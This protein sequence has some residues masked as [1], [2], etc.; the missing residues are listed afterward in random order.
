MNEL[1]PP[2]SA[3]RKRHTA[4]AGTSRTRPI[5]LRL[6]TWCV[7]M[8]WRT[9]VDWR[10]KRPFLTRATA[11]LSIIVLTLVAIA[12]SGVGLP[13]PRAALGE[14]SNGNIAPVFNLAASEP[15]ATPPPV[16]PPSTNWSIGSEADVVARLPIPHTTIPERVRAQVTAYV[17]Q[18]GDT[19]YDI[20]A[21]FGL[22]PDTI[23][24]SNREGI[25]DAPWLIQPGLELFILPVDGVYHTALAGESVASIA[26]AYEVEPT[27]LYNEWNGLEDGEQP[28]EGQLLVVPG[29]EGEQVDWT[30]PP[31]YPSPGP[32]GLSY[33]ICRG[34]AVSGPGGNGWFTYPTGSSRVSGWYFHD[35]RNPTHI[36]L[37]YACRMGDPLYAA[38]NGVVTIA[39]WNG[40]Y[41]ILIEVNHG[42]GF[43]TRYGHFSELAVGCG[44]SV[45]QGSLLG[46]CGSTGWSSG[47]HLHF[48]IRHQ[49]TPQDPQAYLP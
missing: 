45:Y 43:V 32:A 8:V 37:D 48:E 38:D 28:H 35:P 7:V 44:Q 19:I 5:F 13:S 10:A 9:C 25:N 40:G 33:G 46:Y 30:P 12:L 39:G 31:L 14:A 21:Q 24:W 6:V 20:A 49:G 26:G 29:G 23:V 42:N 15:Q 2:L 1:P 22:S 17:V 3:E 34:T 41:G 18:A 4:N 47:A 27:A 36:G 11:H 16:L